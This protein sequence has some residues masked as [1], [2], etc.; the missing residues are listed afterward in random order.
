[1]NLLSSVAWFVA[2][3]D[4][5]YFNC[6]WDLGNSKSKKDEISSFGI[7]QVTPKFMMKTYKNR[8]PKIYSKKN[9]FL[10]YKKA[11]E[12]KTKKDYVIEFEKNLEGEIN[13]LQF[14]LKSFTY[15]PSKLRKFIIRDSKTRTIHSS[16]FRDRVI[17][18]AIVNILEPI[19]EPIFIFDSY[20][21]RLN[22]GTHKAV[23]K[24][25][26]FKRKVSKNHQ[27]I[28][29]AITNNQ[30][31]GYFLKT[32][33]KKYFDNVD[34]EILLN[35]LRRKIRDNKVL[36]L[37]KQILD[38]FETKIKE[39]GMPLGNLTSQFFA[40][41]YLNELDYFIKHNLK[42]RY[43]IRYVDDFVILHASKTQLIKWKEEINRFL[44]KELKLEL[45]ENKS[46]VMPLKNGITLLGYRIYGKYKLLRKSNL[47]KFQKEFNEMLTFVETISSDEL[48]GKLN[49]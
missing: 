28:K 44:M 19:Y 37:I 2:G 43:Y 36:G 46:K 42:A 20:A 9:L 40:N 24:F 23:K 13:K 31:K 33:I 18:H 6:Y 29:N 7:T 41:V 45:H 34:H 27:L 38:N 10:A 35:I 49:G 48:L 1:M 12:D 4:W 22:K 21:S 17:H 26:E 8:Y 14:E 30:I 25:D 39:K 11:R 3:S 32:D 47:R 16:K 5:S 15:K